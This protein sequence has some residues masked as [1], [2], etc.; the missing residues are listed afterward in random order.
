M[1]GGKLTLLSCHRVSCAIGE[2]DK[3]FPQGSLV[4]GFSCPFQYVGTSTPA[5]SRQLLDYAH[6]ANG[7]LLLGL[8]SNAVSKH[9]AGYIRSST[10]ILILVIYR[11]HEVQQAKRQSEQEKKF[12]PIQSDT[13]I[14]DVT[15]AQAKNGECEKP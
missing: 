12:A 4:V 6:L 5:C 9:F 14:E 11:V 15:R 1:E 2:A 3:R 13:K 10:M 7:S 8:G